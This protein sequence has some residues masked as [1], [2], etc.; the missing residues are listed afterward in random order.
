[1][2]PQVTQSQEAKEGTIDLS[3]ENER[4][5]DML[6][7]LMYGKEIKKVVHSHLE[8]ACLYAIAYRV[9][10]AIILDVAAQELYADAGKDF[11]AIMIDGDVK[12]LRLKV[13][14]IA[15][16]EL[17]PGNNELRKILVRSHVNDLKRWKFAKVKSLWAEVF[18]MSGTFALDV[19][20]A[21][22][23]E[24]VQIW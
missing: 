11:D 12:K 21:I 23:A 16:H 8:R 9:D 18:E 14:K 17:P 4:A 2:I 5:V 15:Y 19:M 13:I 6:L 3:N 1:M 24:Q 22:E 7:Q 10:A 20:A